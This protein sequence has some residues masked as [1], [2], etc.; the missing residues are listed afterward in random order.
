MLTARDPKIDSLVLR[1]LILGLDFCNSFADFL[2]I[3]LRLNSFRDQTN[4]VKRASENFQPIDALRIILEH[5]GSKL[6]SPF[7]KNIVA[8]TFYDHM[9]N[10]TSYSIR[11]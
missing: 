3:C 2:S 1:I 6:L 9:S 11:D 7:D 5:L 10:D 4:F 8:A